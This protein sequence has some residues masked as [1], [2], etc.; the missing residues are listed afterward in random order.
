V[1]AILSNWNASAAV[2]CSHLT[3][4]GLRDCK[5]QRVTASLA[6]AALQHFNRLSD[7]LMQASSASAAV[8]IASLV[9]ILDLAMLLR[10]LVASVT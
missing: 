7:A 4:D 2:T 9:L 5:L 10:P 1:R 8:L 6:G 3:D